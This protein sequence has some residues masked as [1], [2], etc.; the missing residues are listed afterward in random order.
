M[1]P[2]AQLNWSYTNPQLAFDD[3]WAGWDDLDARIGIAPIASKMEGLAETLSRLHRIIPG[4]SVG[5]LDVA[6]LMTLIP[7]ADADRSLGITV[8]AEPTLG[9]VVDTERC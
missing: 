1:I 5:C 4:E 2:D 6:A 3:T 7:I 8:E 9:L